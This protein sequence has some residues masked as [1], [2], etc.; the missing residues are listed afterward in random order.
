MSATF[1]IST[2]PESYFQFNLVDTNGSTLLI[3]AEFSNREDAEQAITDV[4]LG[5][6]MS[7]QI[8]KAQTKDSEYFFL[9]KDNVG[10]VLAKSDLYTDEM[11][12]NNALNRVKET[13]C[14][15]Q[16]A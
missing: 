13:A 1:T 12:F 8:A 6:L 3:G 16:I 14:I 11:Q 5:S 15:A 10:N 7:Q 2:T 9:I 4:R